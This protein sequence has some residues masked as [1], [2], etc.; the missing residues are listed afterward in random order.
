MKEI[1]LNHRLG[2]WRCH[3]MSWRCHRRSNGYWAGSVAT[4]MCPKVFSQRETPI[5]SFEASL[6]ASFA[7][8][9]FRA[10]LA[11]G[12]F[13]S[14]YLGVIRPSGGLADHVFAAI[15]V[16][17]PYPAL[18]IIVPLAIDDESISVQFRAAVRRLWSK[19]KDQL[20]PARTCFFDFLSRNAACYGVAG[21]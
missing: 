6:T 10:Q 20:R 1:R 16:V 18:G 15:W 19:N 7:G 9:G 8:L 11:T 5:K 3:R 21:K 17:A 4:A 14:L 2:W 13:E 12:T